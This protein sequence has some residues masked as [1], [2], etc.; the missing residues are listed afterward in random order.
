MDKQRLFELAGILKENP[1]GD[2]PIIV[3]AWIPHTVYLQ[4]NRNQFTE[5]Q[6]IV[7]EGDHEAANKL[8]RETDIVPDFK[9]DLE[10]MQFVEDA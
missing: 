9:V 5:L 6:R 7:Q 3:E 10:N 4:M 8:I 1:L 2:R